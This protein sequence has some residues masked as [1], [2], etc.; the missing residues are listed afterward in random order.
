MK[1]SAFA[2]LVSLLF[3]PP[4]CG[5]DQGAIN[6]THTIS[7]K[8]AYHSDTSAEDCLSCGGGIENMFPSYWGQ[9]CVALI[10]LN[11]FEI[12]T[13][14]IN[15]Y[16]RSNG[17]LTDTIRTRTLNGCLSSCVNMQE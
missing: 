7:E 16:D 5:T 1:K 6:D 8:A 14:E 4:G 11:T 9:N 13:I 3:V 2:F 10:S 12:K 17:R 15:R